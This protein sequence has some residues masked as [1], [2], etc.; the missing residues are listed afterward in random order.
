MDNKISFS[1]A[2]PDQLV[3]I[4]GSDIGLTSTSINDPLGPTPEIRLK[5]IRGSRSRDFYTP[6]ASQVT[7]FP[8]IPFGYNNPEMVVRFT[9]EV[10]KG[11]ISPTDR[12]E[13]CRFASAAR[14]NSKVFRLRRWWSFTIDPYNTPDGRT[15]FTIVISANVY[16]TGGSGADDRFFDMIKRRDTN[17]KGGMTFFCR[18]RRVEATC[19]DP[20]DFREP[21][22]LANDYFH[23]FSNIVKVKATITKNPRSTDPTEDG[24]YGVLF[25]Y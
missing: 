22:G 8:G 18:I 23:D 3:I 9:F 1:E 11:T 10:V 14:G 5:S 7:R 13:I 4:D 15:F 16:A 19:P 17:G 6:P 12:F 25:K 20:D 2:D 24:H 21:R